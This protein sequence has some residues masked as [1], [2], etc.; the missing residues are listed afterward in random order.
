MDLPFT[1]MAKVG[2]G[3]KGRRKEEDEEYSLNKL[4]VRCPLESAPGVRG[5]ARTRGITSGWGRGVIS[6]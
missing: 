1:E 6:I 4:G 5:E 3:W 2:E